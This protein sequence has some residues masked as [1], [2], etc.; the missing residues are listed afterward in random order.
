[1]CL[2]ALAIGVVTAA[3]IWLRVRP[4]AI[5]DDIDD[6]P[7][8]PPQRLEPAKPKI[9]MAQ[10]VTFTAPEPAPVAAAP[11]T[12]RPAIAAAVGAPDD[13]TLIKGVGPKL[14]SLLVSLGVTRFDQ[15]AAWTAQDIGEVDGFLGSF[16]GRITRDS[17][18]EQAGLLAR[19]D[20]AG[21][22]AKFGALGSEN[23]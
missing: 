21:F 22:A 10:P 15:I 4:A 18:V 1:L 3:W 16:K 14:N 6:A 12:G 7:T 5:G 23:R 17:W 11:A 2:A 20:H 9:D 19:G 8:T 13:L